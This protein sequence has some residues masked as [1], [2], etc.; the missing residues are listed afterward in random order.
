[1]LIF[2][3]RHLKPGGY[4]E[5]QEFQYVAACDDDSCSGPYAWRDFINYLEQGMANLGADLHGITSVE[6]ELEEAGFEGLWR[7][8]FKCPVGPWA[9]KQRLQECGHVLRDVI[10]WGLN[11]LA[12]RPFRDGLGWTPIQIEMFLVEVRKSISEEVNGLPKFHS[13]YPYHCI[14]ARKPLDAA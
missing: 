3:F 1:V 6:G 13:Y 12:K 5:V 7:K 2:F 14:Y 11:G 8:S 10:M 9:K 4:V